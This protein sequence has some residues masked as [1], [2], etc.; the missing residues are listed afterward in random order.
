MKQS[1]DVKINHFTNS[2]GKKHDHTLQNIKF[3]LP[4]NMH[5]NDI[6]NTRT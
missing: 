3:C 1:T 6:T 2:N 5:P 4:I